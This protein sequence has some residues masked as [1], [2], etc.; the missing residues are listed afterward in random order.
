MSRCKVSVWGGGTEENQQCLARSEEA[1][2]GYS[3]KIESA[4][5]NIVE[6]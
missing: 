5:P 6:R 2:I 4:T 1:I 3:D